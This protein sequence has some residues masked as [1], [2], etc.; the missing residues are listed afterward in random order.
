MLAIDCI[1]KTNMVLQRNQPIP[2]RGRANPDSEVRVTLAG[3]TA[4]TRSNADGSW[5]LDFAALPAGGPHELLIECD[6]EI[7][8][9][10]DVLIGDVWI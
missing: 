10:S 8:Q 4:A 3:L 9:I 6:G 5:E 2:L 7:L 1:Y